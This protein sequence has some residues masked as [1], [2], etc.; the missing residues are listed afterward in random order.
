MIQTPTRQHGENKNKM[1]L[2]DGKIKVRQVLKEIEESRN[3]DGVL[4][5]EILIRHCRQ[6]LVKDSNNE[7]FINLKNLQYLPSFETIRRS[8]QLVQNG[9]GEYPPTK[10]EVLKA[11][12]IKE[13]NYRDCEIRETKTI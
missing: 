8:R 5:E 4:I 6:F 12:K 11:R 2:K 7:Y 3:N 13:K 10:P 1:K 9:D